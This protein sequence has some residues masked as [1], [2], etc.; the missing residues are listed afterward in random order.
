[1]LRLT[2][3]EAQQIECNRCGDCCGSERV[4]RTTAGEYA[5]RW[6]RILGGEDGLIIP[7]EEAPEG[8]VHAFRCT[9]FQ[10]TPE[11]G[12][13]TA[14]ERRPLRCSSFPVF[15]AHALD[16]AREVAANGEYRLPL[17]DT[18]FRCAWAD[19]VIVA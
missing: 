14:Y 3:A 19:V 4:G 1:M 12:K 18:L 15:G 5:W 8:R 9:A 7:L 13:C 11:E 2:L 16:I 10:G 17:S 6:G